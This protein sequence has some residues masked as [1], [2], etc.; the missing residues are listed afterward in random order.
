[1]SPDA[2]PSG[3]KSLQFDVGEYDSARRAQ[4]SGVT[5]A[6]CKICSRRII[7][8]YFQVNRAI[9]CEPCRASLDTP[10]GTRFTRG[11]HATAL[12]LLA[13]IAGSLVYFAVAAITGRDFG[14]VA[15]AVGF[16]VGKAVRKG[17][18]GA[19]GW[20]YQTLAIALTYLVITFSYV[21]LVAKEVQKNATPAPMR[22]GPNIPTIDTITI[23]A[24]EPGAP[25]AFEPSAGT[26]SDTGFSVMQSGSPADAPHAAKHLG[27]GTMLLGAGWLV[28]Y[29][30]ETPI[31]AG[32]SHFIGLVIIGIAVFMAWWLNRRV[33]I[34]VT[35]PYRLGNGAEGERAIA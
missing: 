25:H 13:T 24:H 9:I 5:D 33:A 26:R 8:T 29:A 23:T 12:G 17:S 34:T 1:M 7:S 35:G 28:W 30:A 6:S 31:I 10:R 11:L 32:L 19:G 21:P 16:V 20:V 22:S 2:S 27:V 15:I 4:R 18:R 3:N 14:L